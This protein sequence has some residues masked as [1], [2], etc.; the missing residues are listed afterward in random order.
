MFEGKLDPDEFLE[1]LDTVERIFEYKDV[2]KD[3]KVKLVA[4][5]FR[6]YESLWWTNLCSK[7]VRE[8]KEKI[9]TRKKMKYKLIAQF[10]PPLYVQGSYSQ[11]HNLTQGNMSIDE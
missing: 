7:K 1:C 11:L 4:L 5:K 8:R 10:L 2:P 6:K 9:K 3:K